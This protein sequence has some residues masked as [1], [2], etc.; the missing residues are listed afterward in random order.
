MDGS[1]FLGGINHAQSAQ[2]VTSLN[3]A[4][5]NAQAA[6][7]GGV[8]SFHKAGIATGIFLTVN[9]TD[10]IRYTQAGGSGVGICSSFPGVGVKSPDTAA[11]VVAHIA[12][13]HAPLN[14]HIRGCLCPHSA[15]AGHCV[16]TAVTDGG[17][18]GLQQRCHTFF[19]V[20]DFV[21]DTAF[22][23]QFCHITGLHLAHITTGRDLTDDVFKV[24]G[25]GVLDMAA[26]DGAGKTSGVA[27]CTAAVCLAGQHRIT[28]HSTC[29]I[30]MF[31]GGNHHI[32]RTKY[33]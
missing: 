3:Q 5:Q 33:S 16:G 6:H 13:G 19:D 9:R 17:H 8:R 23:N 12:A 32:Q 22:S 7:I 2:D 29:H 24:M 27:Q 4:V 26:I 25:I 20:D 28:A 15:A 30:R 31:N 21:Q 14:T 11:H 10:A 18:K 1:I